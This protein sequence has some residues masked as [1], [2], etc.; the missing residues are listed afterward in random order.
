[1]LFYTYIQFNLYLGLGLVRNSLMM[2]P[3]INV[4]THYKAITGG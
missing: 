2:T 4:E 1:M 3:L